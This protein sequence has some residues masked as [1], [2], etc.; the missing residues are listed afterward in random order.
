[1]SIALI[2]SH[3]EISSKKQGEKKKGEEKG[4]AQV[5]DLTKIR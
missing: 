3:L 5:T 2:I 4:K 1:M